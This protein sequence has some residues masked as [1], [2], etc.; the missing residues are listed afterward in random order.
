VPFCH[1]ADKVC[2]VVVVNFWHNGP[3]SV[4]SRFLKSSHRLHSRSFWM[5]SRSILGRLVVVGVGV[6]PF[7]CNLVW[8]VGSLVVS[9]CLLLVFV[10]GSG[11]S[12]GDRRSI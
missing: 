1:I 12:F 11:E 9:A 2:L 7:Q 8:P 10:V 4:L 3:S 6:F 5:A